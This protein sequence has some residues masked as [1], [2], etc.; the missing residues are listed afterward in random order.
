MQ[1]TLYDEKKA[2]QVAAYFLTKFNNRI[3][4]LK[5]MKLMYI[6]DR[7]SFRICGEPITYDDYCSMPHGPVLSK[8]YDIMKGDS[9]QTYW[10]DFIHQKNEKE[11][12]LQK[13]PGIGKLN[14]EETDILESVYLQYG[15]YSASELRNLTH[16][17]PEYVETKSSKPIQY[18]QIMQGIGIPEKEIAQL[19]KSYSESIEV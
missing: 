7:E 11:I 15:N 13:N 2:T 18:Q 1:L 14:L 16:N 3:S 8:T 5:L 4:K 19:L 9:N 6:A 12:V 17:F 10:D